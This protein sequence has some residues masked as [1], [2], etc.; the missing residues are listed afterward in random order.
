MFLNIKIING[1]YK[2]SAAEDVE[3]NENEN[4]S[5]IK[6]FLSPQLTGDDLSFKDNF[7]E[8]E[9]KAAS[10]CC[11]II[12]I[13]LQAVFQ[14]FLIKNLT[15]KMKNDTNFSNYSSALDVNRFWQHN[16]FFVL[17][18]FPYIFFFFSSIFIF[19]S[20]FKTF[21]MNFFIFLMIY[22]TLQFI[23]I[24]LRKLLL[25]D[26]SENILKLVNKSQ[27]IAVIISFV[28]VLLN[29]A[30][31]LFN[32]IK[33]FWFISLLLTFIISISQFTMVINDVKA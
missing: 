11:I 16:A 29:F 4:L 14:F 24:L 6:S 27:K 32:Q 33:A 20:D 15:Y 19:N 25:K 13:I 30:L 31:M 28:L 9:F 17:T 5:T 7:Y 3:E 10:I 21:L 23:F 1:F 2:C 26:A 22:A 12:A 8:L 18:I